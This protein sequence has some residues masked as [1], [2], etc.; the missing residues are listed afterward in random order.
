MSKYRVHS[1]KV[2]KEDSEKAEMILDK[3]Q[4]KNYFD[5]IRYLGDSNTVIYWFNPYLSDDIDTIM[6]EF[7]EAGIQIL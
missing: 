6:D 5:D 3:Y 2:R 1:I 4:K 7:K